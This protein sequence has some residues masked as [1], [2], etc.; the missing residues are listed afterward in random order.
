MLRLALPLVVDGT[1]ATTV[2]NTVGLLR[3]AVG[4]VASAASAVLVR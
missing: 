1:L 2:P 4:S 3:A